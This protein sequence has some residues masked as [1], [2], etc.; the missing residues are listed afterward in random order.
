MSDVEVPE[1]VFDAA[2]IHL[3]EGRHHAIIHPLTNWFKG[4]A[5]ELSVKA[6]C[7][8]VYDAPTLWLH[9]SLTSAGSG[10]WRDPSKALEGIQYHLENAPEWDDRFGEGNWVECVVCKPEHGHHAVHP[11][12]EHTSPRWEI[13]PGHSIKGVSQRGWVLA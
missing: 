8:C 11:A 7:A 13:S 9:N 3:G 6:V 1:A 10:I 5:G 4:E 2:P 12:G